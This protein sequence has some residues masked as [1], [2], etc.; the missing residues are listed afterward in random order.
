M[1]RIMIEY[2]ITLKTD[3]VDSGDGNAFASLVHLK[4]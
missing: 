3:M 2:I 4:F 1:L